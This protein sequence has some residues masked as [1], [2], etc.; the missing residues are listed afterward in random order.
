MEKGNCH[1]LLREWLP[2]LYFVYFWEHMLANTESS[3]DNCPLRCTWFHTYV[4]DFVGPKSTT[5]KYFIVLSLE[6]EMISFSH[7]S[8]YTMVSMSCSI[9]RSS[10]EKSPGCFNFNHQN[11][12]LDCKDWHEI[13][14]IALS[15]S[16]FHTP[17]C[18]FCVE[19][20]G[21][22]GTRR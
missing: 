12:N 5:L 11:C 6:I 9:K 1:L 10:Y 4:F 22:G 7:I 3:L 17:H 2:Y 20:W 8:R 18:H 14:I 15:S 21:R 19:E 16:S 13:C